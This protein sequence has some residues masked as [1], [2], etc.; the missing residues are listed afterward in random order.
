MLNREYVTNYMT[1]LRKYLRLNV[2]P[3]LYKTLT[4][5]FVELLITVLNN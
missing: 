3:V 2:Q 4:D 5:I 1:M